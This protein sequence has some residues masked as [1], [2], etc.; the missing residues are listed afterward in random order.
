MAGFAEGLKSLLSLTKN[1]DK[2]VKVRGVSA[3]PSPHARRTFRS[4]NEADHSKSDAA[5]ENERATQDPLFMLN[6]VDEMQKSDDP[7]MKVRET[8]TLYSSP[9]TYDRSLELSFSLTLACLQICVYRSSSAC[10]L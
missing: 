10:R 4:V 6:I 3:S 9:S 2:T 8:P 5:Y 1:M 7:E